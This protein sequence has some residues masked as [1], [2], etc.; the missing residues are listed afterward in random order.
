MVVLVLEGLYLLHSKKSST[1]YKGCDKIQFDYLRSAG[2]QAKHCMIS[3]TKGRDN[4]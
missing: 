3:G 1:K 2:L 4:I